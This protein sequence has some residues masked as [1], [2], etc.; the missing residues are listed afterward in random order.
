MGRPVYRRPFFV[1]KRLP[2][3]DDVF[4]PPAYHITGKITSFIPTTNADL[5]VT[6]ITVKD[7]SPRQTARLA[8]L[9]LL[10]TTVFGL[11]AQ[12][13]I[14]GGLIDLGNASTTSVRIIAQAPFY[15][16]GFSIFMVEMLCQIAM[17]L[18]LYRLLKPVGSTMALVAVTVGIAGCVI[19]IMSRVFYLVPLSLYASPR[20]LAAFD[21][22]QVQALALIALRVNDIGAG[23]ALIFF[24][25]SSVLKGYLVFRSSFLPRFLG[26]VGMLGGIGW[27]LYL[28]RPM[29]DSVFSIIA[30]IG[31]LA[32]ICQV[33]WLTIVGVNEERWLAMQAKSKESIW[34]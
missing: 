31:L 2:G 9:S 14:V 8:G 5:M 24:G 3:N 27:T 13:A 23:V 26:I 33:L 19:K 21:P 29:A 18:F 6:P 34:T 11:Y 17:M 20:A 4:K 22:E 10:L 1:Y 12:V 15:L 30:L 32:V 28:Y 16:V 25:I 7:I